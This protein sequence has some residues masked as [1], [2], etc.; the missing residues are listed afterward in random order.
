MSARRGWRSIVVLACH[1]ALLKYPSLLFLGG[2]RDWVF[3]AQPSVDLY[4]ACLPSQPLT[5][6]KPKSDLFLQ[7]KLCVFPCLHLAPI[8]VQQCVRCLFWPSHVCSFLSKEASTISSLVA[9][10]SYPKPHALP[11]CLP[12]QRNWAMLLLQAEPS[13]AR[14]APHG[15][16][17]IPSFQGKAKPPFL[18]N[19]S[20]QG[21]VKPLFPSILCFR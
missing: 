11:P 8:P 21:E 7:A 3:K 2:I 17:S 18:S 13:Q 12:C 20:C 10:A 15:L 4:A 6:S 5:A 16:P 19:L 1:H 9:F 14:C